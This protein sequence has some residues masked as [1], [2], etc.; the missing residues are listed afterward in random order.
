MADRPP[1]RSTTLA[2]AVL[3]AA[4]S[5]H[6]LTGTAAAEGAAVGSPGA[7]PEVAP[8]AELNEAL[9]A[10]RA[11]LEELESAAEIAAQ[12][13]GLREEVRAL[14]EENQRLVARLAKA[15]TALDAARKK[16]E[17]TADELRIN[18][19]AMAER[20]AREAEL[21]EAVER[22]S[23]ELAQ[24]REELRVTQ[25]QLA[26]A[27]SA[28]ERTRQRVG[29][30]HA[31]LEQTRTETA[32]ARDDFA[33]AQEEI[34][35]VRAARAQAEQ[36]RDAARQEAEDLQATVSSLESDLASAEAGADELRAEKAD[37]E[38]ELALLREAANSATDIARQNLMAME[39]KIQRLH[40]VLQPAG[41]AA[42]PIEAAPAA[43]PQPSPSSEPGAAL[44]RQEDSAEA[45]LEG[46]PGDESTSAAAREGESDGTLGVSP[47]EP[48]AAKPAASAAVRDDLA[49]IKAAEASVDEARSKPIVAYTAEL[50]LEA[51]LQVQSLLADLDA[52]T[53]SRGV[54]VTVPSEK[55]FALG[56]DEIG[57]R[58]YDTLAKVAE[59]IDIYE[60]REVV[61]TGHTDALGESVYNRVLS[62]RRADLVRT[63]FV[64]N[65]GIDAARLKT[66]GLREE[67]PGAG[68]ATAAG[69]QATKRLEVLI[70]N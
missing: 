1:V 13:A 69:P 23:A 3:L 5:L 2:A 63:F 14:E 9:A 50:P 57:A 68:T 11:K 28:H 55:L 18:R 56:S 40:S 21:A 36:E 4:G 64:D 58:A 60:G 44:S 22:S 29:E 33:R 37:T 32:A 30:L 46:T 62:E 47:P 19:A 16:A 45:E 39:E 49:G 7:I 15:E 26:H 6:A 12:A 54:L 42:P 41:D 53:D 67:R 38:E 35:A 52:K 17:E 65:F 27:E 8:L 10:A 59:I 20:R 31:A 48:D 24:V 51:R 61:I 66:E 43:P 25:E 70:L 34:S